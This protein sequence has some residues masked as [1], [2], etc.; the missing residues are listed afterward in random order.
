MSAGKAGAAQ[1]LARR[2]LA[3][4]PFN[5]EALRVIGLVAAARNGPESA[6]QI[7]TLAGDWS[8]RDGPAQVWLFQQRLRHRDYGSAFAH[9]DALLR[10]YSEVEAPLFKVI[11]AIA[12][13]DQTAIASGGA[14]GDQPALARGLLRQLEPRS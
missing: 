10:Q 3:A 8:L 11:A 1:A 2:A 6:D 9:A 4:Q 7:M 5:V 13:A 12:Q 14:T